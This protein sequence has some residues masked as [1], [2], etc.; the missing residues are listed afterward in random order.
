MDG[1]TLD[2]DGYDPAQE[3][4]REALL[5]LGNGVFATRGAAPE[6]RADAV[7]YPGTYAAG[8]FNRLADDV[9]GHSIENESMVNLPN[10]LCLQLE[11]DGVP[12][13]PDNGGLAQ[14]HSHLDL[15]T[16]VLTRT[17][18][19]VDAWG[20]STSVVQRRLV[21]LPSGHLAALQTVVVADNWSGDLVV[22]SGIDGQVQ[23]GGVARYA[24]LAGQHFSSV[25]AGTT[26]GLLHVEAST[27][28]SRLHVAVAAKTRVCR[29][30]E[31]IRPRA[32][33][34][35]TDELAVHE[36]LLLD[37][38]AGRPVL[39]DKVASLVTSL[40]PA[41]SEPL[42]H[43]LL[44]V[45]HAGYF[46][47]LLPAHRQ[48]WAALWDRFG[49]ELEGE[50][51]DAPAD[52]LRNVRI[53]LFH[54]LQ[55]VAPHTPVRDAGVP[56]RGL[57]GEA[58][59]GHVFWD[60]VFVIPQLA[61]RAP[62]VARS[63]VLYRF[64]RLPAAR[65][66]ARA[67]GRRGACFPWQ[68]GSDGSEQS[69]RLHLNPL[70]GHWIEDVTHLQ[71]HVGIAIALSVW[72]Y[73]E[74]TADREFL[75]DYGAQLMA[76]VMLFFADSV[77]FDSRRQRFV[78]PGVV[79]PD[80]FHTAYPG[81]ST[82]GIDDN[83]YTN[84]MTA[85]LA[86]TTLHALHSLSP[87]RRKHLLRE[88]GASSS[89]LARWRRIATEMYV[90][91]DD[92][93]LSQFDGY[94][95]LEE[96]DWSQMRTRHDDIR[97]LDRILEAEGRSVNEFKASKQADVLMLFYVLSL[98]ELE[99]VLTRLGYGF[100][101]S[102]VPETV[103]YYLTRTCHGSTLSSVVHAWVLARSQRDRALEF[104]LDVVHS[105]VDDI[106]G[107]TTA[108]GVHLAA[109]TAGADLLQ[110]CFAGIEP[111]LDAL[112]ISPAWPEGLGELTCHLRYQGHE[113]RVV[114]GA[115]HVRL[116]SEETAGPPVTV[117]CNGVGY[118]LEAEGQLD[119]DLTVSR[120]PPAEDLDVS[121]PAD[122]CD[123]TTR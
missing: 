32:H 26:R 48:A 120:C 121:V 52:F 40:E 95:D 102:C 63:L 7:H 61:L 27:S 106:Q 76:E 78:L 104:L 3:P 43:A 93:R 29:D 8:F 91:F 42:E 56:A 90:P 39:V 86:D 119:I 28:Q 4:L 66:A 73:Y 84:V 6:C 5:T 21:D 41:V 18:R 82:P 11:L 10:W 54:L 45:E 25:V 47:D 123:T 116:V 111:R 16:G 81:R 100:D 117:V 74:T 24:D 99:K 112:Y 9:D 49:I 110:R 68:S 30:G 50:V 85:W 122:V 64:R 14:D 34:V 62:S 103:A 67:L 89:D 72:R 20:R 118:R 38:S 17:L 65:R 37:L 109:M 31:S 23:N 57:H 80:E 107:G 75:A 15:R 53:G 13:D 22:R 33:R 55:S 105:D 94:G 71:R 97:R 69:Q 2:Y 101:R 36:E 92:G 108:E 115:R 35:H 98:D 114:V 44:E 87:V 60:E 51:L 46:D 19:A 96:L 12:M 58:Y 79:G 59:R 70:S 77:R 1:W 113:L 88:L 83:A